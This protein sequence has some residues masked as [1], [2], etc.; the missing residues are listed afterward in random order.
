VLRKNVITSK[1]YSI[2][3]GLFFFWC[4]QWLTCPLNVKCQ[5]STTCAMIQKMIVIISKITNVI[6]QECLVV[7]FDNVHVAFKKVAFKR[8]I[9]WRQSYIWS[10]MSK[11]NLLF[12][13]WMCMLQIFATLFRAP[14]SHQEQTPKQKQNRTDRNPEFN[15]AEK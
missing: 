14:H 12:Y 8:K 2:N 3:L 11:F 4:P 13:S 1:C 5:F 10:Q 6:N 9:V 15:F 7:Y